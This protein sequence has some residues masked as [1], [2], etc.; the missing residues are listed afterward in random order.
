VVRRRS[1]EWRGWKGGRRDSV[2][3][4]GFWATAAGVT[5]VN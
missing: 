1:V 5:A 2:L 3:R 4:E